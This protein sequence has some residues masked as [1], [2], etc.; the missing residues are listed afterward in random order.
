MSHFFEQLHSLL[1]R[2]LRAQRMWEAH[3]LDNEEAFA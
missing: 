2:Q 3:V 1:L